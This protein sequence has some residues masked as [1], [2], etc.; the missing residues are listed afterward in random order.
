MMDEAESKLAIT[1]N[2]KEIFGKII[3]EESSVIMYPYSTSS[4]AV[5]V[6]SMAQMSSTYTDLK[7]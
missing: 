5:P 3:D 6:T 7:R 2:F 4:S 1:V